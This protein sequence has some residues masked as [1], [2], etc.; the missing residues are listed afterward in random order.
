MFACEG[1]YTDIAKLLVAVP[2]L[3]VNDQKVSCVS[4]KRL[5]VEFNLC[6]IRCEPEVWQD[7]WVRGRV[8]VEVDC[9]SGWLWLGLLSAGGWVDCADGGHQEGSHGH[10]KASAGSTRCG[11]EHR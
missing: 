1:G 4:G 7:G 8:S 6:C 11:C 10:R 2:G 9:V 3:D 5:R